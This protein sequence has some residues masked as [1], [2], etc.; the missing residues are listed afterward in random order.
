MFC[1][2]LA[3]RGLAKTSCFHSMLVHVQWIYFIKSKIINKITHRASLIMSRATHNNMYLFGFLFWFEKVIFPTSVWK[4]CQ[5][6]IFSWCVNTYKIDLLHEVPCHQWHVT[7][8]MCVNNANDA[9]YF[10]YCGGDFL[11]RNNILPASAAKFSQN[12][13]FSQYSITGA[14]DLVHKAQNHQWHDI[15]MRFDSKNKC[16]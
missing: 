6:I 3:L 15:C 10:F 13:M 14:I 8:D 16:V 2:P 5:N 11:S 1:F 9:C 7:L 4:F 12:T